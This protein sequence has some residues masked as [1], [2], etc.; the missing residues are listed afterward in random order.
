MLL[1]WLPRG[2]V[3]LEQLMVE[4][5]PLLPRGP[6]TSPPAASWHLAW[7]FA[8]QSFW[9]P[10]LGLLYQRPPCLCGLVPILD[11]F[12]QSTLPV[13]SAIFLPAL[14]EIRIVGI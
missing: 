11:S 7:N 10:G 4:V 1:G 2:G 3:G 12:L 8:S 13:S 9:V 6:A 5:E 14:V